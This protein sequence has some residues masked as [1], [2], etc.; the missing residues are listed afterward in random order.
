MKT[1]SICI[2]S[3]NRFE[4]LDETLKAILKCES[5]DYEIVI[6][7]N[8]SP[9]DINEYICK[10]SHLRIVKRKSPV[11]GVKNVGDAITYADGKFA[12]L[13]LDKDYIDGRQL[14]FFLHVLNENGDIAGGYC[15]LNSEKN[16]YNLSDAGSVAHFG[17][18]SKHPSGNFYRIELLRDYISANDKKLERDPFPF[19]IYLAFCASKGRMM[20]YNRPLVY[21]DLN[22]PKGTDTGTL[23]FKK[24]SNNI[25]YFPENRIQEFRT[26][27]SCLSEL[28][29]D[30]TKKLRTLSKL[31][32]RTMIQ[33]TTGLK[34]T[35]SNPLVCQHYGHEPEK[36]SVKHMVHNAN[37]LRNMFY[38]Q[39]CTG[40][41]KRDKRRIELETVG[42]AIKKAGIRV[43]KRK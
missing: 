5:D 39:E 18:L 14:E 37:E 13:L 34:K 32:R 10:D 35:M 36:V 17:Y 41:E 6:V 2:P 1:L 21:S 12:L 23:T 8:C 25:Y 29:I 31:Y 40:I 22:N 42:I 38:E 28:D 3:Y 11:Y 16:T 7:D 27:V 15:Q 26:Y 43:V 20:L 30:K 4:K 33:V 24:S 9:R 19:D